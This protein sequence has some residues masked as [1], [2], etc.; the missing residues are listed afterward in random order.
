M[1]GLAVFGLQACSPDYSK[2][3]DVL[4]SIDAGSQYS[5]YDKL[6]DIDNKQPLKSGK[7]GA[8]FIECMNNYTNEWNPGGTK[9]KYYLE[10]LGN[11]GDLYYFTIRADGDRLKTLSRWKVKT[12]YGFESGDLLL[13]I[14][15][16]LSDLGAQ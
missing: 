5:L 1:L 12:D 13:K 6:V 4:R 7:L 3:I 14:N 16:T 10:I 9:N 15:C 8:K 2:H 11:H